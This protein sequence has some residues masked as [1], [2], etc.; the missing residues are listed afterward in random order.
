MKSELTWTLA[1]ILAYIVFTV[2]AIAA[3]LLIYL[4]TKS[5]PLINMK[6]IETAVVLM[7]SGSMWAA[8][9]MGAKSAAQSYQARNQNEK[10]DRARG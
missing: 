4:A 9:L 5:E 2:N 1:K 3:Y 6:L 10:P 8:V 7:G